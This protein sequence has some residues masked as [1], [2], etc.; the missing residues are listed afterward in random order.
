MRPS[1]ISAPL[2]VAAVIFLYSQPIEAASLFFSANGSGSTCLQ[3]APCLL[4]EAISQA[5]TTPPVE[6]SCADSNDIDSGTVNK[7]LTIDC[8]GTAGSIDGIEV[9]N[10]GG[11][12]VTLKNFTIGGNT[13][14]GIY[15]IGGGTL[16]LENVHF[17]GAITDEIIAQPSSPST[18]IVRNCVFDNGASAIVLRPATSGSLSAVFDH[19]TISGNTGGGIRIDTTN[20]PVTVD[21]TDSTISNNGGNGI[22]ALGNAGGQAMVSIKNSVIAKNGAAGVQANG[23]N[24]GV[25]I[26]TTLLDQNAAGATTVVNGGNLLTYGNNDVVG[27]IGSGFTGT[28]ALH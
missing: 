7:S 18:L 13:Y 28:A 21:I 6:L 9:N 16:I 12:V 14:N 5:S 3:S 27:S 22:N 4:S 10:S 15:W 24:A 19:V 2:V 8:A 1:N 17:I 26:S 25:L 20:G 11:G 23:A